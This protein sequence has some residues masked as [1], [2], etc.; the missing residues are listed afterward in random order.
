MR[1]FGFLLFLFTTSSGAWSQAP[2]STFGVPSS[3]IGLPATTTCDFDGRADRS[4][5]T[6]VLGDGGLLMVG[7]S[8]GGDGCD[9]ALARL[10]P[11]GKYD[12][13]AGPGGR[14]RVDLGF[15]NDSCLAAALYPG[16]RLL[17]GGCT[18][19]PGRKDHVNL[20]A[21]TDLYGQ[22]DTLF[23]DKG[24][25]LI[26]L[27]TAHEMVTKVLIQPDGKIL[28][29]GNA[30][31]GGFIIGGDS[32]AVFVGRLLPDGRI[33]S[34]F[35]H[36]GFLYQRMEQYCRA[37]LLGDIVLDREG[38]I[39][40]TGGAY[41]PY[42]N[43]YGAFDGCRHNI[44]LFRFLSNGQPDPGFGS[45]GTV[46]IPFWNGRA[47]AL[48]LEADDKILMAGVVS[49][50]NP[51]PY[52]TFLCRLLPDGRPD[53][54]FAKEGQFVKYIYTV[55]AGSEP[56]GIVK[57]GEA[58]ILGM[59]DD[60]L[61]DNIAF[62]LVCFTK[63]GKLNANFGKNGVFAPLYPFALYYLNNLTVVDDENVLL[64]G[65][66]AALGP[67]DMYIY[68]IK[69]YQ[70]TSSASAP[71]VS[72]LSIYPNPANGVFYLDVAGLDMEGP[73][74]LRV[75]DANGRLFMAQALH[76]GR[77]ALKIDASGLAPGLYFVTLEGEHGRFRG[78]IVVGR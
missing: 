8:C 22:L 71:S 31:Y 39:L 60:P 6:F 38:K 55:T 5:A 54:S 56:F 65:Y 51:Q 49:D 32:T 12:E 21:R 41:Q 24:V 25:V 28:V 61:G 45:A 64:G 50:L 11:D 67:D 26:D 23:G 44:H 10:L 59:L 19:L 1:S 33:D 69:T 20:V 68:K 36:N 73:M 58:I 76:V 14:S 46:D 77:D 7:H 16:G 62:G 18:I 17:V 52:Y 29:A 2:D 4:F 15:D 53:L 48:Y 42:P 75:G 35:A 34:T 37:S 13:R 30:F 27:P 78:K 9:L 63:D 66:Y 57:I 43:N 3:F 70:K 74:Q 72:P 47:H 40:V